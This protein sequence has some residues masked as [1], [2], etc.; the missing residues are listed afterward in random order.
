MKLMLTNKVV[1][2]IILP[3]AALVG[4]I[5]GSSPPAL[6]TVAPPTETQLLGSKPANS[7]MHALSYTQLREP[8]A[9]GMI[10]LVHPATSVGCEQH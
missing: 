1:G 2:A 4:A 7:A 3:A 10:S 5:V 8:Q 6:W 9:S